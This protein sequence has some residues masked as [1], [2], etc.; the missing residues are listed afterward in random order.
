MP[1]PPPCSPLIPECSGKKNSGRKKKYRNAK[2][3]LNFQKFQLKWKI[4]KHFT[5]PKQRASLRKLFS[6]PTRQN[7]IASLEQVFWTKFRSRNL[8]SKCFKNAVPRRKEMVQCKGF[9]D[10]K[11]KHT[12]WKICKVRK[13]FGSFL[14]AYYFQCQ[15][16]WGS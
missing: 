12:C 8:L 1:S 7:L 3:L 2:K 16:S 14:G 11:Q 6:H 9:S 13:A 10:A 5:R 4:V 15:V